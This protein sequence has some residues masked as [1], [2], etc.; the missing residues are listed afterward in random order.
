MKFIAENC[1]DS[2]LVFE[3]ST[4]DEFDVVSFGSLGLSSFLWTT[5]TLCLNV[6]DV[7]LSAEY[8]QGTWGLYNN[9]TCQI[10]S[11]YNGQPVFK[12]Q[13]TEAQHNIPGLVLE[14]YILF[15]LTAN[16]WEAWENFDSITGPSC[17]SC[18]DE[19][20]RPYLYLSMNSATPVTDFTQGIEWLS[21]G[22]DP[23]R[24]VEPNP[25]RGI[26]DS[27]FCEQSFTQEF[28]DCWKFIP[29]IQG[30]PTLNPSASI[31]IETSSITFYEDCLDCLEIKN[32]P[33]CIKLTDCITG[34][35]TIISYSET[36]EAYV[37]K[38]IKLSVPFNNTF[39]EAC[40]LV[41]YSDECPEDPVLLPGTFVACFETCEACLPKCVCTRAVNNASFSKQLSYIDCNNE[42]QQTVENVQ[43]GKS[44]LKYCVTQWADVDVSEVLNFGECIEQRCPEIIH[45]KKFIAPGYDTPACTPAK[46]EKI[47][48]KYSELKYT[49]TMSKRYG[50]NI[51]CN[52]ED[53]ISATIKFKLL[54]MQILEDP[55][56]KC[57]VNKHH[58]NCNC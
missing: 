29:F 22:P 38:V 9:I 33:P 27:F 17:P 52:D 34:E 21:T 31:L 11:T 13:I 4:V 35:E 28:T 20:D 42:L 1:V 8:P 56:Y 15:N 26:R 18:C 51:H 36:Y 49:E 39:I 3:L 45:P 41:D 47:V 58:N 25:L 53:T 24:C 14:Y 43:S 48:C 12:F 57:V 23:E 37:G 54:Q 19:I 55:N 7:N 44:S 5:T 46:Y 30:I 10:V 16:Q 2:S 32:D 50:L 40:Y 6:V